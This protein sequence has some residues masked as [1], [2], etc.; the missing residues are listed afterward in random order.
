MHVKKSFNLFTALLFLCESVETD[1]LDM[2][3]GSLCSEI[4]VTLVDPAYKKQNRPN[5]R[6]PLKKD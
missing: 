4:S 1:Q 3:S 2:P 5:E 6:K